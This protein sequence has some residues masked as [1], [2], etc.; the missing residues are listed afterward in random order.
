MS[1]I[2]FYAP[3]APISAYV[4]AIVMTPRFVHAQAVYQNKLSISA[5]AAFCFFE[6]DFCNSLALTALR[7]VDAKEELAE[8][9]T[10]CMSESEEE[11]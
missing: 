2:L 10:F 3:G 5:S 9:S 8:L 1:H 6:F 4:S 7:T 11:T